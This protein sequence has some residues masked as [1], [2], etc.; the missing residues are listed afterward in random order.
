MYSQGDK[1]KR[2]IQVRL[3]EDLFQQ[4]KQVSERLDT[5]ISDYVRYCL[6]RWVEENPSPEPKQESKPKDTG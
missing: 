1:M 6:R 4:A 5:S 3:P 2:R